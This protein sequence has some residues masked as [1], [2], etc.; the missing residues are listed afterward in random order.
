[1]AGPGVL[2]R[3]CLVEW[4]WWFR[5]GDDTELLKMRS[6]AIW[7]AQEAMM[8]GVTR[9]MALPTSSPEGLCGGKPHLEQDTRGT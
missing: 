8:N 5:D 3:L 6:L 2:R 7:E 1:M 4:S 9:T